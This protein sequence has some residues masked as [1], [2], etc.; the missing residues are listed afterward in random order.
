MDGKQKILQQAEKLFTEHGYQAVSIRQIAQACNFT[1]AALY[2][3]FTNKEELFSAV[4]A[5]HA[6]RLKQQ[7]EQAAQQAQNPRA[8]LLAM[9]Q[10]YSSLAGSKR[11]PFFLLRRDS[12]ALG[13]EKTR[14]Q[15]TRILH[16]I[17]D[18]IENVLQQAIQQGELRA[19]PDGHSPAALL[20]GMLH[21]MTQYRKAHQH[22]IRSQ[23][24][25]T[26]VDIF[27]NGMRGARSKE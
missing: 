7:M 25:Q 9:L 21:G 12:R 14:Q 18:P 6:E 8:R 2:Y 22:E 26:V 15:F 5:H 17:L 1:N 20:F 23:D 11:S 13:E 19:L 4:M 3:H 24:I 16:V 10:A 27:W